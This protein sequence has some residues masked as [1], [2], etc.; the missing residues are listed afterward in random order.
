MY[1]APGLPNLDL[2][3]RLHHNRESVRVL[4]LTSCM[5]ETRKILMY[6]ECRSLRK[7][8]CPQILQHPGATS[9]NSFLFVFS[10][11][12]AFENVND[13]QTKQQ[14]HAHVDYGIIFPL[15][16]R[17]PHSFKTLGI[18]EYCQTG[19]K[20]KKKIASKSK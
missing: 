10:P 11:F 14:T 16:K 12:V 1:Y 9:L 6:R 3:F 7:I 17:E 18:W 2:A 19:Q 15:G 8:L 13:S 20:E 5:E 4:H